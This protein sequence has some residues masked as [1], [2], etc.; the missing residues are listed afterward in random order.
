MAAEEVVLDGQKS[1]ERWESANSR[2]KCTSIRRCEDK[3]GTTNRTH[4]VLFPGDAGA[5]ATSL[6]MPA[7]VATSRIDPGTQT[8][9]VCLSLYEKMV[10]GPCQRH[11]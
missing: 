4:C 2:E 3:R 9:S 6:A 1:I 7:Y 8:L 5:K 11:F 10:K